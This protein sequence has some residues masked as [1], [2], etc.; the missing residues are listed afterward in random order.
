[1]E[2][3]KNELEQ[4]QKRYLELSAENSK[5]RMELNEMKSKLESLPNR[6]RKLNH[7]NL[8]LTVRK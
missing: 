2:D 8:R 6:K 5:M 1:M 3:L 7:K 4:L